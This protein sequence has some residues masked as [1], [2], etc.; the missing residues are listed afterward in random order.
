[1]QL[2]R[3]ISSHLRGGFPASFSDL[4]LIVFSW[5]FPSCALNSL[6]QLVSG[7]PGLVLNT[8]GKLSP[9][10]GRQQDQRKESTDDEGSVSTLL[11]PSSVSWDNGIEMD[12]AVHLSLPLILQM[13]K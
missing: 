13:G 10:S 1:M 9:C 6:V 3:E 12:F 7:W 11:L 4:L 2:S 8:S 5:W